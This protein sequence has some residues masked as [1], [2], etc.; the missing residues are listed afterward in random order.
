MCDPPKEELSISLLIGSDLV[1]SNRS[2]PE[3]TAIESEDR[4]SKDDKEFM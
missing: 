3:V 1:S 4:F 2:C